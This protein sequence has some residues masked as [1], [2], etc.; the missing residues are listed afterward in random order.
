MTV[1]EMFALPFVT[2]LR[3]ELHGD[4]EGEVI[5]LLQGENSGSHFR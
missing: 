4:I 2:R 3:H 1:N 5:Q